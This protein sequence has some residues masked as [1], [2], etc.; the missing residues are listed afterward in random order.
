MPI[1]QSRFAFDV[2]SEAK[3]AEWCEQ[4]QAVLDLLTK[5]ALEAKRSGRERLS[6]NLL[7]E[8]ARW[9]STVETHGDAWKLNNNWRSFVARKLMADVPELA[10]F[11]ETRKSQ[12]DE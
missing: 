10:G 9:Y 12:A 7:F 8:R 3:F 6:I 1:A 5:Y 11:F 4:N 2:A